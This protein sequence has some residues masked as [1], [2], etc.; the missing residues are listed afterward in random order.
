M[1]TIMTSDGTAI[2]Y[3]EWGKGS[4]VTFSHGWP[5]NSDAWDGQQEAHLIALACSTPSEGQAC[6]S[7]R[8]LADKL[9]EW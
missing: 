3:K 4:V 8:L 6:W 2:H 5:L 9:I 1:L 7:L